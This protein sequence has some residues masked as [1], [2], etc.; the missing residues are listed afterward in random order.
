MARAKKL[1]KT[2]GGNAL[3]KG[4]TSKVSNASI[5]LWEP[6]APKKKKKKMLKERDTSK[7]KRKD[8]PAPMG[9]MEKQ[10]LY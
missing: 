9:L 3:R 1:K 4:Y 8:S 10:G 2:E 6:A 5:S 7:Y